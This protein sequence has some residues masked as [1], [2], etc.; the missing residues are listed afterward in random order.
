[1]YFSFKLIIVLAL[2]AISIP[3]SAHCSPTNQSEACLCT[4]DQPVTKYPNKCQ[5]TKVFDHLAQGNFSAF[6][7][8]VTPDVQW[9]LMGTH[10]L[11]GVYHNRTIFAIDALQRLSKTL[12]PAHKTSLKLT[13]IVGGGDSEWSVQ[14]LH[15]QGVCKNGLIYDN[16]FN[17][18]TRWNTEGKIAECRGY[19]DS[20]LV[21][22]AITENESGEYTYT[23]QRNVLK[24][25]PVGTGCTSE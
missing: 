10:A 17:W 7:A 12:D 16:K 2:S 23:D 4:P 1:M 13:F 22:R 15:G 9:T 20:A 19:L 6:L 21:Q 18:V 25:G 24:A 3:V 14:E 8:Q 5:I 11:A